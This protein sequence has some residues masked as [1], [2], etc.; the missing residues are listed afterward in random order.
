MGVEPS[1]SKKSKTV[2]ITGAAGIIGGRLA[3]HM[4]GL[5]WTLRLLDIAAGP[6]IHLADL[7]E[8]DAA[9]TE[10]FAGA[11]AVVHLGAYREPTISWAQGVE[12]MDMTANVLRA[13]RE[14]RGAAGGLR[15]L[16]LGDGWLPLRR[17]A[18]HA[19][20]AA[21]SD[22]SVWHFQA[23]RRAHGAGGCGGGAEL[24]RVPHRLKSA[25]P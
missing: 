2:V 19:R 5:G 13:A 12:N 16:E 4:R 10:T 20:S 21:V 3:A 25:H 9:W 1:F 24:H 6:G 14:K 22:Q 18:P 23:I 17:R 8:F 11:D 7:R 15:Q